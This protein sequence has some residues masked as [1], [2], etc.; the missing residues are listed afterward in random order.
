MCIVDLD[1]GAGKY[2]LRFINNGYSP[3]VLFLQD[4]PYQ[5]PEAKELKDKL[6]EVTRQRDHLSKELKRTRL[7]EKRAKRL[8]Q[9]LQEKFKRE[10]SFTRDLEAQL[11]GYGGWYLHKY[12]W[13]NPFLGRI[14]TAFFAT[15]LLMTSYLPDIPKELFT[16]PVKGFSDDQRKFFRT[17]RSHSPKAYD[18]LRDIVKFPLPHP[19]TVNR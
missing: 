14:P 8:C 7:R 6:Y 4:H 19:R 2:N 16:K 13:M 10:R 18:Y 1:A 3:W 11:E 17:L 15:F 12:K 9:T 5:L